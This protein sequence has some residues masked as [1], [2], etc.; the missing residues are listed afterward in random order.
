MK[1]ILCSAYS[2]KLK[3]IILF[4][5]RGLIFFSNGHIC[6]VFPALPNVVEIDVENENVVSTLSNV[7]QFNVE[8]HNVVSTLF[9]VEKHNVILT[10]FNVVN[11]NVDVHNVVSTL[12]WLCAT[13]LCHVNLKTTLNRRWNVWWI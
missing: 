12:I 3:N 4:F 5:N 6:N 10:L 1:K 2:L 9:N 7:A 13:S 11:F 8:K